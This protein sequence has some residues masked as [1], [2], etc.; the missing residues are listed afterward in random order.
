MIEKITCTL[1][2]EICPE[3]EGKRFTKNACQTMNPNH[4]NERCPNCRGE[5]TIK[6]EVACECYVYFPGQPAPPSGWRPGW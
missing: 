3:C 1:S 2:P 5:G 4:M 6:K